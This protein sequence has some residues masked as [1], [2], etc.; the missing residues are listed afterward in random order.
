MVFKYAELLNNSSNNNISFSSNGLSWNYKRIIIIPWNYEQIIIIRINNIVTQN[1]CSRNASLAREHNLSQRQNHCNTK[2]IYLTGGEPMLGLWS[3]PLWLVISHLELC[4]QFGLSIIKQD[5]EIPAWAEA[6]PGW[7]MGLGHKKYQVKPQVCAPWRKGQGEILRPSSITYQK[8][9]NI[10]PG[11]SQGCTGKEW[12]NQNMGIPPWQEKTILTTS[13]V[14]REGMESPSVMFKTYMDTALSKPDLVWA[15][16]WA[17]KP[18]EPPPK[19][20]D[21]MNHLNLILKVSVSHMSYTKTTGM[22]TLHS[23]PLCT[24]PHRRKFPLEAEAAANRPFLRS[25]PKSQRQTR[26]N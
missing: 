5:I 12:D 2:T 9:K 13:L 20:H 19:V 15:K 11:S 4:I 23:A 22:L 16:A 3:L 7:F 21:S 6:S 14:P 25:S 17:E 24:T 1:S 8:D 26:S 10:E 18:I